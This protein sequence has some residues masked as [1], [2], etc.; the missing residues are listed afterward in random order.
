MPAGSRPAASGGGSAGASASANT[1]ATAGAAGTR[2]RARAGKAHARLL[3][4]PRLGTPEPFSHGSSATGA[5]GWSA[6][7]WPLLAVGAVAMAVV[8][9]AVGRRKQPRAPA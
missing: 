7:L 5:S 4:L 6:F 8:A 3:V 1:S 2:H 9:T